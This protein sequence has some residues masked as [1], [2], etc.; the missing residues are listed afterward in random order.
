[1][2]ASFRVA[3]SPPGKVPDPPSPA[4][5]PGS[6]NAKTDGWFR[7][8]RFRLDVL[9]R[10]GGQGRGEGHESPDDGKFGEAGHIVDV[11]LAHDPFAMGFNGAHAHAELAGDFLVAHPIGDVDED[12][13]L[14]LGQVGRAQDR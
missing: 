2:L 12:F 4:L 14:A 10:S 13:P 11:E 7:A 6:L 8:V 5:L 9:P 3:Q 1:M